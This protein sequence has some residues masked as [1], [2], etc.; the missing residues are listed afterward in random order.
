MSHHA[1]NYRVFVT[2]L[3]QLGPSSSCTNIAVYICIPLD[4]KQ[5]RKYGSSM[6]I[7]QYTHDMYIYTHSRI[8][9]FFFTIYWCMLVKPKGARPVR[10]GEH[11]LLRLQ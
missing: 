10:G 1:S 2:I 8:W 11:G 7:N 3:P 4:K 9:Y 6:T 5:E